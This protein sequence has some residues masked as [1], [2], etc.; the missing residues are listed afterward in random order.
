[1]Q[2]LL[3]IAIVWVAGSAAILGS[4]MTLGSLLLWVAPTQPTKTTRRANE[5]ALVT[6]M[7][8]PFQDR[9]KLLAVS[10]A[11]AL[12]GLSLLAIVPFPYS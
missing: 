4:L 12:A 1:M 8:Q 2:Q 5:K 11:I 7:T 10:V 3:W 6:T 9:L